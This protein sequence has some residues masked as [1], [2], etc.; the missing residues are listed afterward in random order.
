LC[1]AAHEKDNEYSLLTVNFTSNVGDISVL[2][3][4][5]SKEE[6]MAKRTKEEVVEVLGPANPLRIAEEALEH[7]VLS[8]HPVV[9]GKGAYRHLLKTC[10]E[11]LDA[12]LTKQHEL[13]SALMAV[14]ERITALYQAELVDATAL[15]KRKAAK[16][17]KKDPNG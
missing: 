8:A 13:A 5:L 15:L 4:K 17:R 9:F 16:G 7:T 1:H 2:P 3:S 10:H 12:E 11:Q 6:S 14:T